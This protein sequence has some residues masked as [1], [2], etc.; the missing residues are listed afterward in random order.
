[1][2]EGFFLED[3][4]T[5]HFR[6]TSSQKGGFNINIKIFCICCFTI[7]RHKTACGK[8]FREPKEYS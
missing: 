8:I 5:D 1:M 4:Y 3:F 6:N 7:N 2:L